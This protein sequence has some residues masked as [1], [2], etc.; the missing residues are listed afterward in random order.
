MSQQPQDLLLIPLKVPPPPDSTTL[1]AKPL[2]PG[3][4][5]DTYP[6]HTSVD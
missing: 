3:S 4:L 5:E 1:G 6:N 2:T